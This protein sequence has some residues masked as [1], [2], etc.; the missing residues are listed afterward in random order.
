MK[1]LHHVVSLVHPATVGVKL[2]IGAVDQGL[3]QDLALS[4]FPDLAG[5]CRGSGCR[6]WGLGFRA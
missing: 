5:A 2:G 4:A 6:V 3:H 1:G